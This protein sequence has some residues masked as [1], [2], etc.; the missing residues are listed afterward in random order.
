MK[1]LSIS[2]RDKGAFH[3][4]SVCTNKLPHGKE[5]VSP[6]ERFEIFENILLIF[7]ILSGG[8]A[9]FDHIEEIG[10]YLKSVSRTRLMW[11]SVKSHI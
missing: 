6:E 10:N 11:S 3:H 2:E 7:S 5:Q 9:D 4:Y 8:C 1:I